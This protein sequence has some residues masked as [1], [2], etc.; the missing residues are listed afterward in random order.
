MRYRI[1]L[2][3]VSAVILVGGGFWA[4]AQVQA[5]PNSPRIPPVTPP[6]GF[7][8][9]DSTVVSGSDVGFRIDAWDGDTPVGRWVIRKDGRWVEPRTAGGSVRRLLTSR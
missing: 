1:G 5:P 7:A 8:G 6:P 3:L 4:Q 9:P 2:V